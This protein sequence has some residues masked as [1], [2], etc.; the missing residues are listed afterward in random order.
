ME[1]SEPGR[2]EK[3]QI[4]P[5]S[6]GRAPSCHGHGAESHPHS[7]GHLSAAPPGTLY[8]CPMHPEIERDLPG[9]CP[10]CGMPL[11]PKGIPAPSH[12]AGHEDGEAGDMARRFWTSLAL[13]V[14][15]LV[16]AMAD[17]VP[18]VPHVEGLGL[19]ISRWAQFV[20]AT[21][22]VFWAGAPLFG[23]AWKSVTNRH[24]NMFSLIGLGTGIAY[25]FSFVALV[26][27]GLFP[28]AARDHGG[29][30][31]YFESA[32]MIIT[33]VL[34]GQ[35]LEARARHQTGAALR[36]LL[37][38]APKIARRLRDGN[39]GDEDVPLDLVRTGDR[40]RVRPGE[41]V[42]VDGKILEGASAV[43]ESML[44]GEPVPVEKRA[45][46][47]VTGGT[48]NKTGSFMMQAERVGSET[49]LSQIVAMVSEAQRSR[50]PIQGLADRVSGWFVPAVMVVA[51]LTF[52]I[53]LAVGPHPALAYAIVNAIAVLIIACPCAL[54][55]ATP[56]SIMVGVGRGAREGILIKNAEALEHLE[57]TDILVVDKTGT[58][59]EGKPSVTRLLPS[60]GVSE[61][62]LL[63]LAAALESSSEHPLGAAV[64]ASARG[65][66]LPRIEQFESVPGGGVRGTIGGLFVAVGSA[67]FLQTTGAGAPTDHLLAEAGRE[68]SQGASVV[69]AAQGAACIGAI[70]IKDRIKPTTS[71]AI[72]GLHHLGVEVHML[73]GDHQ[74]TAEAVAHELGIHHL[75]A[76]VKPAQKHE[77]VARLRKSGRRVAMAG[78]GV[79]DAPALAAAD[80]GIAMGAGSDVA[81]ES[82][83]VTLVKG[84]LR[85]ILQAIRL[86][87]A[88]MNNIRQNLVFAF[89][90]NAAGVPIA[91]GVL[92]PVWG[93]LLNP[94]IAGAAMSMSSVSVITNALRLARQHLR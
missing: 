71:E 5:A 68:Q 6:D 92:Y 58:L 4:Q 77:Y 41:K 47:S 15:V 48:L 17:M 43:D 20:L 85:S 14:P 24:L 66:D 30:H 1:T 57:K 2:A 33:L 38:L 55:L 54:G 37:D 16:L 53:W 78:D 49:M 67:D 56:V 29:V 60:I 70:V 52:A 34:L 13:S 79:N 69:F 23:K 8:T 19:Q 32:A 40:L 62:Q 46:E 18:G 73:T 93:V 81:K 84:D 27:P 87:R 35:W 59:T 86:S 11:E 44:T 25:G 50:A 72:A 51:A 83:G 90:Y 88:V 94:M 64:V 12:R 10:K 3:K 80:V 7:H 28:P 26:G 61:E 45:G 9:D 63:R 31:L 65:L 42:P 36:A 76:E 39:D 91:A 74:R 21:P 89:G 75:Q 22:V 82:A